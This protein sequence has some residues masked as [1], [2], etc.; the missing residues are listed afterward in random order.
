MTQD[1]QIERSILKDLFKH[2]T[3]HGKIKKRFQ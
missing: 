3:K 1:E 2:F